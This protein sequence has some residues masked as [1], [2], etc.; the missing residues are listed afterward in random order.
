MVVPRGNVVGVVRLKGGVRIAW[1]AVPRAS[2]VE[3]ARLKG[4]VRIT[5]RGRIGRLTVPLF[6]ELRGV[7]GIGLAHNLFRAVR[8]PGL[9]VF[10]AFVLFTSLGNGSSYA[11][12]RADN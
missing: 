6:I 11:L 7:H 10:L 8:A 3:V 5:V 12:Q 9:R 4:S 1:M 2:V